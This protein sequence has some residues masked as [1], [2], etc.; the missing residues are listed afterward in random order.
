MTLTRKIK[1][2]TISLDVVLCLQVKS[3]WPQF[4]KD[5]FKIEQWLGAKVK[6][7]YK[8]CKP[9]YLVPKYEGKGNAEEDGVLAKGKHSFFL[10]I[11][12]KKIKQKFAFVQ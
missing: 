6:D 9:F 4:T 3:S 7:V 11:K 10:T 12:L 1:S 8:R 2:T 5:G